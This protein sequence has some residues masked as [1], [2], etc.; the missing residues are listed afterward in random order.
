MNSQR[1]FFFF[2]IPWFYSVA[3]KIMQNHSTSR[4]AITLNE[5]LYCNTEKNQPDNVPYQSHFRNK[6]D[7]LGKEFEN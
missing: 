4:D 3:N 5:A 1:F 2:L 7:I 6:C